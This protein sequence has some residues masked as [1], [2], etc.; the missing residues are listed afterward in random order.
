MDEVVGVPCPDFR[1]VEQGESL[2]GVAFLQMQLEQAPREDFRIL[3]R[4]RREQL[5]DFLVA[6]GA[7][8]GRTLAG[9][10]QQSGNCAKLVAH[11][12]GEAQK[13]LLMRMPFAGHHALR[14]DDGLVGGALD[15][16]R[17]GA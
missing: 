11:G 4:G 13:R 9:N 3:G 6:D 16:Q 5:A 1:A 15:F 17:L 8:G 12:V 10:E 14:L 2:A 7:V